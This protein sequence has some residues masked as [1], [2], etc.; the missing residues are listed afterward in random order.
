MPQ[1]P[2]IV[3]TWSENG[4]VYLWDLNQY[5]Q[6]LDAPPTSKLG[7]KTLIK[8]LKYSSEGYAIDWS[9]LVKG[10]LIT[11][12][13]DKQIFVSEMHQSTW[14]QDE[15]PFSGHSGSVE[16]L[17]WSPTEATVF[18]SCSS[19]KTIK[20]WDTRMKKGP[21]VSWKAADCDVNVISW[22]KKVAYLLASGLDDGSFKVWDL[23]SLKE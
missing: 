4:H 9:H 22:N 7:P 19:D 13:C 3:A 18:S 21:A 12:N 10:R 8:S 11:G 23:R 5:I 6:A 14:I 16:D 20:I 2:H 1:E 17:S 15:V